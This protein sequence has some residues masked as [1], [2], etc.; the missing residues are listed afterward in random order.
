M[1]KINTVNKIKIF[2]YSILAL[3]FAIQSFTA[4][5][6]IPIAWVIKLFGIPTNALGVFRLMFIGGFLIIL[7]NI[8]TL[9][10]THNLGNK[11]KQKQFLGEFFYF[12]LAIW[13]AFF[14][15]SILALARIFPYEPVDN[16]F[17]SWYVFWLLTFKLVQTLNSFRDPVQPI[18]QKQT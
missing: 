14:L 2:L 6:I 15:Y 7:K 13:F 18:P 17:I 16:Q 12:F 9:A 8:I 4:F 11:E 3:I 5:S 1:I 10:I